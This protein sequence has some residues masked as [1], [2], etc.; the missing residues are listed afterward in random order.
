[1]A[2]TKSGSE[3]SPTSTNKRKPE[4]E[5]SSPKDK[6]M[7]S[8]VEE[9]FVGNV[10]YD[11]QESEF[12]A[13]FSEFGKLDNLDWKTKD[14]RFRGFCY[15]TYT[16]DD[17]KQKALVGLQ[18]KA[19]N[20]RQLC[21]QVTKPKE[22]KPNPPSKTL[23]IGNLPSDTTIPQLQDKFGE[24]GT[25]EQVRLVHTSSGEF[26]RC[27]FIDFSDQETATK[28]FKSEVSLGS[29]ELII[30]YNTPFEQRK[31]RGGFRGQRGGPRGGRGGRGGRRR[32]F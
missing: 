5:A 12:R 31:G 18:N 20:G 27:A 15:V 16:T 22:E 29:N 9:L 4:A 26:K 1:M 21:C 10:P 28:V 8:S 17:E 2:K 19:V 23:F 14:G 30:N 13:I 6:V 11:A 24:F 25:V 3:S 7:R 32:P